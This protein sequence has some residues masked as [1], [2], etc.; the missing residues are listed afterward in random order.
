M[1]DQWKIKLI[2]LLV[3]VLLISFIIITTYVVI[4]GVRF[5]ILL[6][7]GYQAVLFILLLILVA[8]LNKME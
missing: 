5:G 7:I 3:L 1:K 6:V 2:E 4:T 8:T